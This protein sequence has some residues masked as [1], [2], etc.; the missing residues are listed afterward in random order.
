[1]GKAIERLLGEG[2]LQGSIEAD[3]TLKPEGYDQS[4][5]V[6]RQAEI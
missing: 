1:M 4:D 6:L 2:R 5:A 3:G